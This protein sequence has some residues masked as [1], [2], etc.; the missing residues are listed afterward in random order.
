MKNFQNWILKYF[1]KDL[2]AERIHVLDLDDEETG[3]EAEER[4]EL[5]KVGKGNYKKFLL[6]R[7]IF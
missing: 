6:K 4:R 7:F 5:L 3:E 2:S 1:L